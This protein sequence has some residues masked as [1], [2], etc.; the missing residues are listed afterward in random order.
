MPKSDIITVYSRHHDQARVD[1][2]FLTN[3]F[4]I[5]ASQRDPE[6]VLTSTPMQW[7]Q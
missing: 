6:T 3:T 5:R 2:P 7:L 1:D 4:T